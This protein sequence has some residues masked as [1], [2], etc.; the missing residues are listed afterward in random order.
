MLLMLLSSQGD[1]PINHD[2]QAATQAALNCVQWIQNAPRYLAEAAT[3]D[4][5]DHAIANVL[6][7]G[8]PLIQK[9]VALP[10]GYKAWHDFEGGNYHLIAWNCGAKARTI[11]GEV[12][13]ALWD[14]E[15]SRPEAD[16][17][18][19]AWGWHAIQAKARKPLEHL[20]G[21][22]LAE[23]RE[24]IAEEHAE[25]LSG[26]A[27]PKNDQ[28]GEPLA[29]PDDR[30]KKK[31]KRG[32]P[33][34]TDLKADKRIFDAWQSGHFKTYA[35]LAAELYTNKREVELV[36]DRHRRRLEREAHGRRTN[37]SGK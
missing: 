5:F 7:G 23:L 4:G 28:A 2:L 13:K 22:P 33:I 6:Q 20:A 31:S 9:T 37:S 16:R 10:S 26:K 25:A 32:R 3:C 34:D 15:Q 1:S 19:S 36:I 21:L 17:Q 11:I 12:R 18:E 35:A 8:S 24:R 14:A 27:P 29:L 30:D